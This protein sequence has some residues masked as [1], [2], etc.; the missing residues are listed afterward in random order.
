MQRL[1]VDPLSPP[2]GRIHPI[3]KMLRMLRGMANRLLRRELKIRADGTIEPWNIFARA[4]PQKSSIVEA[5]S[6]I[7]VISINPVL[8]AAKKEPVGRIEVVVPLDGYRHFTRDAIKDVQGQIGEHRGRGNDKTVVATIGHLVLTNLRDASR[9]DGKSIAD[10]RGAIRLRV[11]I[12]AANLGDADLANDAREARLA[13]DYRPPVLGS[14]VFPIQLDVEILDPEDNSLLGSEF[15]PKWGRTISDEMARQ[16]AF[17]SELRLMFRIR[18][19]WPRRRGI[20][21]PRMRIKNFSLSWPTVTSLEPRSLRLNYGTARTAEMQYNPATGSLQWFDIPLVGE[22]GEQAKVGHAADPG[23]ESDDSDEP[24]QATVGEPAEGDQDAS[25]QERDEPDE[26]GEDDGDED[27]DEDEDVEAGNADVWN[28]RSEDVFLYVRQPGQLRKEAALTGTVEVEVASQLMSGIDA[29]LFDAVGFR[30]RRGVLTLKT[31]LH[32]TFEIVL[33]DVFNRR[34]LSATHTLH[35]DEVV[36]D[37]QRVE[38]IK[39]ALRDRGFDVASYPRGKDQD[40]L[41]WGIRAS[42]SDGPDRIV[43]S[44]VVRGRR[45]RTTRRSGTPGWHRYTSEMDSGEL[46]LAIHGKYPRHSRELTTEVNALRQALASRFRNMAA[47]R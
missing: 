34:P 37:V 39:A 44:I 10:A 12:R 19:A 1:T 26:E 20:R 7:Q 2:S 29:R 45:Y 22:K 30:H 8:R 13:F 6:F 17:S 27:E 21:K 23:G 25:D 38:D 28:E 33:E 47:Q 3:T 18:L 5:Y 43:L 11:P 32:L 42:R 36:P 14:Y 31:T 9:A 16:P 24:D 46:R 4:T 40:S 41:E 35:F 15:G